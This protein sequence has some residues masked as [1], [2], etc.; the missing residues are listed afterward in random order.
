MTGV[1]RAIVITA[2]VAAAA[3]AALVI[4]RNAQGT[5]AR[6]SAA[7]DQMVD[8][9]DM[10]S[11][12]AFYGRYQAQRE[13]VAAARAWLQRLVALDSTLRG[14][15]A[16]PM[17]F[18]NASSLI[19]TGSRVTIS[20]SAP[21]LT[22]NGWYATA[23]AGWIVCAVAVGGDTVIRGAPQGEVVCYSTQPTATDSTASSY[24]V[25]L[26]FSTRHARRELVAALD[27][28][29]V[30]RADQHLHPDGTYLG[31]TVAVSKRDD[32][33]R[34]NLLLRSVAFHGPHP[35]QMLAWIQGLQ[36]FPDQ[37]DLPVYGEP[38]ELRILCTQCATAGDSAREHF[39][40]GYITVLWRKLSAP[41]V[42]PV[43]R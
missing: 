5:G 11:R 14:D 42:P 25:Q 24:W 17:S 4:I 10:T 12:P 37:R 7:I 32:P 27:T 29:L 35:S 39:T 18:L 33:R 9:P 41:N 21:R 3:G 16:Y 40:D 30:L 26:H 36:Y 6:V 38:Y 8:P 2:A 28:H 43:D 1:G 31:W 34:R 22:P 19:V 20:N 15:S 13:G 23:E